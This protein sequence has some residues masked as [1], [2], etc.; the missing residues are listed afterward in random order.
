MRRVFDEAFKGVGTPYSPASF[1]HCWWKYAESQSDHLASYEQ[2]DAHEF[3]IS[4][5]PTPA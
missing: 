3:Y 1:L 4:T 2:Q 5:V